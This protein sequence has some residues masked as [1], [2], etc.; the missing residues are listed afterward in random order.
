MHYVV[1]TIVQ[2]SEVVEGYIGFEQGSIKDYGRGKLTVPKHKYIIAKG[3]IIPT[4][5]NAHTHIGDAV[6]QALSGVDVV[7][8]IDKL[9]GPPHGLKHRILA[10][11]SNNEVSAAIRT[12]AEFMKQTG[13]NAFCDFREQGLRGIH[14]LKSGLAGIPIQS[15]I[16]GRP[17]GLIYNREEVD[18][19]LRT[20][21]GIG[22]SSITDWDYA[23]LE[24]VARHTRRKR[25]IFMLHA[26]EHQREDIDLILN[27][28][29]NALVHMTHA[30]D[31]DLG[32]VR[33]EGIP[34]IV[35]PRSN[36]FFGTVPRN[37][38][39]MHKLGITL[40]LG[41]DNV[42]INIPSMFRE[43][44]FTY[45]IT[46]LTHP[47]EPKVIFMMASRNLLRNL[48]S[49]KTLLQPTFRFDIGAPANFIVIGKRFKDPFYMIVN[50][51]TEHD[52]VLISIGDYIW[53]KQRAYSAER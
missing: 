33:T 51:C 23:E 49:R 45:K 21:D 16:M 7:R 32:R 10:E 3:T 26:S 15:I 37:I 6:V 2:D 39:V 27:L 36:V 46:G 9:V 43:M 19:I 17:S 20:A 52:I 14:Q 13:T 31:A 30:S 40:A 24:K 38:A 12:T 50:R 5:F 28:K 53:L 47:I 22:V 35:C 41:T 48:N 1:G 34:I 42:M 8:S 18:A 4:F 11:C 29:P 25:K 44:E